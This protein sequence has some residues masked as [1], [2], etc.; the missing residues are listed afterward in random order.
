MNA[1]LPETNKPTNQHIKRNKL[2]RRDTEEDTGHQCDSLYHGKFQTDINKNK[3]S[4]RHL[5][6]LKNTQYITNYLTKAFNFS[7]F[8]LETTY[9]ITFIFEPPFS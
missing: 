8:F 5:A 6:T 9:L 1:L 4:A 3:T 2:M 7:I